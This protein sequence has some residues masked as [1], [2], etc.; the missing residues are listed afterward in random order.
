MILTITLNPALDKVYFIDDFKNN[1]VFRTKEITKTAGG[2]G[3]NVA[4][5]VKALGEDIVAT[6]LLGGLSG[7]FIDNKL[8]KHK[9]KN[10][11][12]KISRR[13]KNLY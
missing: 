10:E 4:R 1:N 7:T 12:V 8:K 5:V 11:F 2:K 13:D 3:L 6:G 9:I